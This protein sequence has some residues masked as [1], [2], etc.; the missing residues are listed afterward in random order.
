MTNDNEWR[1]K[2]SDLETRLETCNKMRARDLVQS[3]NLIRRLSDYTA[4]WP[5]CARTPWLGFPDKVESVDCTC[6]LAIL[7]RDLEDHV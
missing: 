3:D 7:L 5:T 6:G 4:H 1:E 2:L